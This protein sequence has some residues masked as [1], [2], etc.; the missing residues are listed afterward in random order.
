MH[1]RTIAAVGLLV[2]IAAAPSPA[3]AVDDHEVVAVGLFAIQEPSET[4]FA[5]PRFGPAIT[6]GIFG[7]RDETWRIRPGVAIELGTAFG[8]DGLWLADVWV[9]FVA[10]LRLTDMAANPFVSF[11]PD[12]AYVA[13]SD[14][15]E[16]AAFGVRADLGIHGV[17]FD[18]LYW[19]AQVGFVAAGVG[20]MRSEVTVGHAFM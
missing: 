20:G 9:G 15:A 3:L 2:G 14:D 16:G 6:L 17:V 5:A 18:W 1:A 10:T 13:A 7:D 8:P 12:A 19:R 4:A 11:G